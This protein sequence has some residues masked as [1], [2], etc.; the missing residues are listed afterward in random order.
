MIEKDEFIVVKT[1][2]QLYRV[3]F[4][5]IIYLEKDLRKIVIHTQDKQISF[6]G[7]MSDLKER[8]DQRFLMCH[9][10]YIFNMDKVA[11]IGDSTLYMK[12]NES[13]PLGRE[14]FRIA[15]KCINEYLTKK[16]R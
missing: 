15:K 12:N 11:L 2:S 10:S 7:K 13:I 6:Y 5:E 1:K 9:R 8:L 4:K 3:E 14:S 16:S